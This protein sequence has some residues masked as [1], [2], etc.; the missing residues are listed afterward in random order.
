MAPWVS[1]HPGRRAKGQR[2][3]FA[4]WPRRAGVYTLQGERGAA[5]SRDR[6]RRDCYQRR[7]GNKL[8]GWLWAEPH[9]LAC[10]GHTN[11]FDFSFRTAAAELPW[12]PSIHGFQRLGD[13]QDPFWTLRRS[14]SY[15][16]VTM[17]PPWH[18]TSS[19]SS[20]GSASSASCLPAHPPC[21]T[22]S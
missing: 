8:E 14:L 10:K 2:K 21:E 9:H 13:L 5:N 16:H 17:L 11:L 12:F 20:Q 22:P 19:C 7:G 4:S 15:L 3:V 18:H 1:T 6:P